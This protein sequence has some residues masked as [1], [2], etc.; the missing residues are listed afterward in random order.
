MRGKRHRQRTY[1]ADVI[2]SFRLDEFKTIFRIG[3]T[4]VEYILEHIG[5][6]CAEINIQGIT[7][8]EGSGGEQQKPL[9]ERLLA[10]LWY[11]ASQDKYSSI[12]NRFNFSKST[13]CVAIRRLL[14]FLADHLLDKLIVWP[15]DAAQQQSSALYEETKGFPGVIGMVDGT[16]IPI[17]KPKDRGID[18]YNRK[19]FYSVVLQA[20]VN[21]KLEFIDIYTG[22]PGKVH[23]A[24]VFRNSPL[25]ERGSALC[26]TYGKLQP[27]LIVL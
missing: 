23:D 6:V 8:R 9:Q 25:Y 15:S 26:L 11:M 2:A 12:A 22:W 10:M 16:H 18:Y 17:R 3:R 21:D 20:V 13:A 4:S 19:D 7:E 5:V 1:F 14:T 24:C 27:F